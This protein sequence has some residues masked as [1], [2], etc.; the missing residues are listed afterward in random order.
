[1]VGYPAC[2]YFLSLFDETFDQN[3]WPSFLQDIGIDG[4]LHI[5]LQITRKEYWIYER[6]II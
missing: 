4:D 2:K 1:M 5:V 3:I 6:S